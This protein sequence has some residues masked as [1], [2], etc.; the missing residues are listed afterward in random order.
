MDLRRCRTVKECQLLEIS[1]DST[2][3]MK[4]KGIEVF[5]T[6]MPRQILKNAL[7][8]FA[9]FLVKCDFP[10]P[11]IV[12]WACKWEI[13]LALNGLSVKVQMSTRR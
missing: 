9:S 10:T 13:F 11:P 12:H 3:T 4:R 7:I 6:A 1:F 2:L 5:S 8:V